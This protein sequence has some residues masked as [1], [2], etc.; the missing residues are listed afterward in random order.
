[1]ARKA[2]GTTNRKRTSGTAA[3][4]AAAVRP[5]FWQQSEFWGLALILVGL[6]TT[7]ALIFPDKG[8]VG[9]AWSLLLRQGFG[10]G[11]YP[12]ALGILAAGIW[13][14]ARH[15][16]RTEWIPRWQLVVGGE[17]AFFGAL[18]LIHVL[19]GGPTPPLYHEGRG[20]GIIGW[21][22]SYITVPYL[23]GAL[24]VLLLGALA[25]GGIYL[26]AGLRWPVVVWRIRWLWANLG[27]HWRSVIQS[28][29][30]RR[31]VA[32]TPSPQ[33]ARR[34]ATIHPAPFE[35]AARPATP[36]RPAASAPARKKSSSRPA[37][38]AAAPR[39]TA[40]PSA[41]GG[42]PP[43]DL[44]VPDAADDGDDADARQKAQIIEDTLEAFGIP[45]QVVEWHR[46]PVVTQFGLEPGYI[47]RPRPRRQGQAVQ[48]ARSA[49]IAFPLQRP[50]PG[51]GG[52]AD[53]HRDP[54]ARAR[55]VVGHGG[56]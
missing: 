17:M 49:S 45:A 46:G 19:A 25:L 5:P 6:V 44:L 22:F 31:P 42:L 13:L 50:G 4:R 29:A 40:A 35:Q 27:I 36:A 38:A 32:P 16:V 39:R 3:R 43:V 8:K 12:L 21:A 1:M 24:S 28:S 55:A 9:A 7:L 15:A 23:G 26:A 52:G 56:A 48:G 10:V 53:P 11:A 34:P 51:P 47:E 20:G 41:A 30:A 54:G 2:T 14:L 37:K 18:G 33:P